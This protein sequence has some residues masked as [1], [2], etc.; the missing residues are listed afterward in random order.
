MLDIIQCVRNH[1]QKLFIL[2]E[3]LLAIKRQIQPSYEIWQLFTI[4]QHPKELHQVTVIIVDYLFFCTRFAQKYFGT[5]HAGFQIS[6]MRRHD[7]Q[8]RTLNTAFIPGIW[9]RAYWVRHILLSPF[10]RDVSMYGFIQQEKR[11]FWIHG[12]PYTQNDLCY[13]FS[14]IFLLIG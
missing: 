13:Y 11:S 4:L 6:L 7:R 3:N 9:D 14:F 1:L 8:N 10:D 5:P 2:T 12:F